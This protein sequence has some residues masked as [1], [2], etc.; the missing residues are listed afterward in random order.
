MMLTEDPRE[1]LSLGLDL[2]MMRV[3]A[4]MGLVH[5]YDDPL[6]APVT[7]FG[8]GVADLN[9]MG[10]RVWAHDP[11]LKIAKARCIA[12]GDPKLIPELRLGACRLGGSV[13]Q[14]RGVAMVPI[15]CARGVIGT[16]ELG[17]SDHPFRA[18]DA[19]VLREVMGKI[20]ARLESLK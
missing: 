12:L 5:C 14:V 6:R 18:T 17:R 4:D 7:R 16:V 11:L 20:V 8:S 15:A 10:D 3:R 2:A 9:A 19:V 1:V 13:E